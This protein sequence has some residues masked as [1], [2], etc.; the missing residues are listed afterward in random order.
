MTVDIVTFAGT[1]RGTVTVNKSDYETTVNGF[2]TYSSTNID[3]ALQATNRLVKSYTNGNHNMVIFIGD[4]EPTAGERESSTA[5]GNYAKTIYNKK[6]SDTT[7][8]TIGLPVSENSTA[9][10]VLS[11]IAT[12]GD[13]E[14]AQDTGD[15]VDAFNKAQIL[16]SYLNDNKLSID[17]KIE[18]YVPTVGS[19]S[20]NIVDGTKDIVVRYGTGETDYYTFSATASQT[21]I[22][23]LNSKASQDLLAAKGI[24]LTYD[25]TAK[26]F[27]VNLR[28]CTISSPLEAP[29]I[30]VIYY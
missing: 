25:N 4:G 18:D 16:S 6:A 13:S 3:A 28:N 14:L 27:N 7:I 8:F 22:E 2:T 20:S 29:V 5:L 17:G 30:Q 24:E 19:I 1:V 26:K 15:L 9:D 10:K 21:S 23:V 12:S 11:A